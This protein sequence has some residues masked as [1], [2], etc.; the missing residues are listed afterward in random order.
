M[1]TLEDGLGCD[2]FLRGNLLTLDGPEDEVAI[3][4]SVVQEISDLVQQG[5][6]I[7]P[8]RSRRS[9]ARSRNTNLRAGSWR[10]SSGRIAVSRGSQDDQSEALR[11]RHP[12]RDDHGLASD[13]P[14]RASHSSP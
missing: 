13:R 5:L 12:Q 2:V 6:E 14:A 4:Q 7:S 3:G 10:T 9:A 8:G 1:K 11:R